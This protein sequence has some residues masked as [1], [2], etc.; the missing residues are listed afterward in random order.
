LAYSV[1]WRLFPAYGST[2]L[3]QIDWRYEP[4]KD[5]T[6]IVFAASFIVSLV[7]AL[8]FWALPNLTTNSLMEESTKVGY[9]TNLMIVFFNL[10]PIQVAGGFVWDGKI[11]MWNKIV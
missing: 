1:I 9:A 4:Q 6:G 10:I 8:A 3:K 2:Y 5:R 11:L 7:L